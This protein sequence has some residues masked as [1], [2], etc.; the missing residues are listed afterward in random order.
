[1]G[2]GLFSRLRFSKLSTIAKTRV[3]ARSLVIGT[4]CAS[5]TTPEERFVE[6]EKR[7]SR[8]VNSGRRKSSVE[9]FE[10]LRPWRWDWKL[11]RLRDGEGEGDGEGEPEGDCRWKRGWGWRCEGFG[12]CIVDVGCSGGGG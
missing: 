2:L 11:G 12:C 10:F 4:A 7:W 5:M 3:L 8:G 1:M 6:C 9:L